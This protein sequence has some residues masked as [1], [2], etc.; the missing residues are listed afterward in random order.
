MSRDSVPKG[1]QEFPYPRTDDRDVLQAYADGAWF[2]VVEDFM[3]GFPDRSQEV[4]MPNVELWMVL[5]V[6]LFRPA[7]R[8]SGV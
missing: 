6:L 4:F 1:Q 5:V 7:T 8:P 2:P 3:T